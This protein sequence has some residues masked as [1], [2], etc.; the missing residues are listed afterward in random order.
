MARRQAFPSL[1]RTRAKSMP[2]RPS[3]KKLPAAP[4][5]SL[6]HV[7]RTPGMVPRRSTRKAAA[8]ARR[9]P[10]EHRRQRPEAALCKVPLYLNRNSSSLLPP[11]LLAAASPT[12]PNPPPTIRFGC[13]ELLALAQVRSP[14]NFVLL[15]PSSASSSLYK[16]SIPTI[17]ILRPLFLAEACLPQTGISQWPLLEAADH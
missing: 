17:A 9:R 5:Q 4:R 6:R 15:L 16:S 3:L 14:S 2:L 11:P 7:Q 10:L 12:S 13:A 1:C 8:N